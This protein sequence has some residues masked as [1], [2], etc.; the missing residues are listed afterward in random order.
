MFVKEYF[1]TNPNPLRQFFSISCCQLCKQR[2]P[3]MSNSMVAELHLL[4]FHVDKFEIYQ[5]AMKYKF[6]N[7]D[8]KNS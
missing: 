6:L 3:S 7:I 1:S 5:K 8:S 4:E 2:L